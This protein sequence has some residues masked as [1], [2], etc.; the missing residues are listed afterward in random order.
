VTGPSDARSPAK[1]DRRLFWRRPGPLY[2]VLFLGSAGLIGAAGRTWS[3]GP[4]TADAVTGVTVH[5]ALTGTV[6]APAVRP[7]ALAILAGSGAMLLLRGWP[8]RAM[9]VLLAVLAAA[10]AFYAIRAASAAHATAWP[11][12]AAVLAVLLVPAATAVALFAGTWGAARR[13]RYEAAAAALPAGET[14]PAT[15]SDD[16]AWRALD[17]GEDPTA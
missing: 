3:E 13:G 5:T 17:R 12:V 6:V 9:A 14:G 2:L 16:D 10:A 8:R 15:M 7:L 4:S 1:P 11:V